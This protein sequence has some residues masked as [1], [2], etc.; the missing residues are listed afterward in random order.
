MPAGR[1]LPTSPRLRPVKSLIGTRRMFGSCLAG[2][3]TDSTDEG[4]T[5]R[6]ASFKGETAG[7]DGV[8]EPLWGAS[9][10]K[11]NFLI[12]LWK[13]RRLTPAYSAAPVTVP[14][15]CNA[16][17]ALNLVS[18]EALI[19]IENSKDE[20]SREEGRNYVGRRRARDV[21]R[22]CTRLGRFWLS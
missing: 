20:P 18:F 5:Y 10:R 16:F 13:V 8:S 21:Y 9:M 15:R 19:E 4:S 22:N 14:M 1:E 17:C 3:C 11:P 12:A 2:F 6:G 7:I